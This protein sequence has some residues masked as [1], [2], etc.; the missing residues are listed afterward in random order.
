LK[1]FKLRLS[2]VCL[3]LQGTS[4]GLAQNPRQPGQLTAAY[5]PLS[6]EDKLKYRFFE[7]ASTRGV[8]FISMGAGFEQIE[9]TPKEW[10]GGMEGY[11]KR[12]ASTF[13][14]AVF[15]ETTSF[16]LEAALHEDPRYFPLDGPSKKARLW[17]V[18]KQT[19]TTRTDSG[20][21]TFAYGR[22]GS[23][24]A[25]GQVTRVWMP[26]S[27]NSAL[28]G[29]RTTGISLGIDAALNMLYEFVPSTRPK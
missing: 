13:G 23:E 3:L 11:A 14:A 15:E 7:I 24:L 10:G 5:V 12:Y 2:L 16:G 18:V 9:H 21:T 28:D 6:I 25:T 1:L 19:F 17:S 8:A 4:V 27:S 29:V 20:A 26:G 22:I